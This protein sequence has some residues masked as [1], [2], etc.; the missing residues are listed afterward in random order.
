[1]E[2]KNRKG[3]WWW[4][5]IVQ[6]RMKREIAT[7]RSNIDNTKRLTFIKN[8]PSSLQSSSSS[9]I[10]NAEA[11]K[12]AA[13]SSRTVKPGNT[14]KPSPSHIPSINPS[15]VVA[16][17]K[18]DCTSTAK[19]ASNQSKIALKLQP[20]TRLKS[21]VENKFKLLKKQQ[22]EG[23]CDECGDATQETNQG[24]FTSPW[25]LSGDG[26][27]MKSK[28][29]KKATQNG[30]HSK[31]PTKLYS[32]KL[33]RSRSNL[34]GCKSP[35]L[36]STLS[37]RSI[38]RSHSKLSGSRKN[39]V[40]PAPPVRTVSLKNNPRPMAQSG[41]QKSAPG[42]AGKKSNSSA[43]IEK[44]GN[45]LTDKSCSRM[46]GSSDKKS[47]SSLEA[48]K[49]RQKLENHRN[50]RKRYSEEIEVNLNYVNLFTNHRF[51]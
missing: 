44:P 36:R 28:N 12:L 4:F 19:K 24:K 20:G 23:N 46:Q 39:L 32:T 14:T 6:S 48:P 40:P 45:E 10:S 37:R 15:K 11:S 17:E 5:V 31:L 50:E 42:V 34:S 43:N 21:G 33:N 22:E 7:K 25:V 26:A 41:K 1:M 38:S 13:D 49:I 27:N 18:N 29:F 9:S 47:L 8:S 51:N 2:K 35:H 30:M 3:K 16:K